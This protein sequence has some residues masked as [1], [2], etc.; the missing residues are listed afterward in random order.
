MTPA[1][2]S[3]ISS[4]ILTLGPDAER[5]ACA[6]SALRQV[7]ELE[8][9]AYQRPWLPAVLDSPDPYGACDQLRALP[10]VVLV[11]VTF[12]EVSPSVPL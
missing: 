1:V 3:S 9:G 6:L 5:E 2:S 10:G 7:P 8:L 12:V 4:L 11:E